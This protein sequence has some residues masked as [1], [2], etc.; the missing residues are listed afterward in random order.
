MFL[1]LPQVHLG[2]YGLRKGWFAGGGLGRMEYP[3]SN[4]RI[5]FENGTSITVE[6]LAY[7]K[8]NFGGVFSGADVYA[9]WLLV[10]DDMSTDVQHRKNLT[11]HLLFTDPQR[12]YSRFPALPRSPRCAGEVDTSG[13]PKHVL[14]MNTSQAGGWYLD[15]HGYKD[16][17]VLTVYS[18]LDDVDE[19][20]LHDQWQ[21]VTRE[22]LS[23]AKSAGKKKLIIDL[24]ANIGGTVLLGYELFAQ[25]FPALEPFGGNRFRAHQAWDE[26]GKMGVAI[27]ANIS[28]SKA[29][30]DESDWKWVSES[31]NYRSDLDESGKPFASWAQKYG[32]HPANGDFHTSTQRWNLDDPIAEI[33]S[34]LKNFT[35][36]GLSRLDLGWKPEDMV[37]IYDGSCSSTCAIFS[38]FMRQK[39]GV[40]TIAMG[41]RPNRDIMQAVGGTKGVGTWNWSRVL[42]FVLS[43]HEKA[44]AARKASWAG[45]EMDTFNT[46]LPFYRASEHPHVNMRDG[47]RRGNDS[48][49]LQFIVEPADCRLYYTPA[50]VVDVT[51]MWIAAADAKWLGK[52]RCVAGGFKDT[53]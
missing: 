34:H 46:L 39:A 27:S 26:M 11:S 53:S 41:G 4:T 2:S 33:F 48:T 29:K 40:E 51:K 1:S 14:R 17:A 6:N 18:F 23:Q 49:P 19:G 25:L 10:K 35:G 20:H 32:P 15:D 22:F 3:G 7:V 52:Q 5:E 30:G 50:M 43:M 38:E 47:V 13:Y 31:L 12:F 9:E 16:I 37:I 28:R 8:R 21:N 44:D 42:W 45:T 24:S 36:R